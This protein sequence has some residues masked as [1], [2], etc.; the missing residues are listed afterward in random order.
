MLELVFFIM[1]SATLGALHMVAPDHW[2]PLTMISLKEH[3][4]GGKI[5]FLSLS[6]GFLHGFSS[7]ILSLFVI[8]IGIYFFPT[9][10][11]KI[12]SIFI[13]IAV[14]IYI[15]FNSLVEGRTSTTAAK[16]TII[17]SVLPDLAV[18]PIIFYSVKFGNVYLLF[19][20]FIYIL[21][22]MISITFVILLSNKGLSRGLSQVDPRYFDYMMVIMLAFTAVYILFFS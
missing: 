21:S 2:V 16:P 4:N 22:S 20:S 19:I 10:Y 7:V 11:I 13:I 12:V 18:L 14:C 15:L 8:F 5:T 3:Y 6:I 17:I 9:Y 1:I